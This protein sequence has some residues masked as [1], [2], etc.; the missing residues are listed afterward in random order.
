M[1]RRRTG[2]KEGKQSLLVYGET[3]GISWDLRKRDPEKQQKRL[4][5]RIQVEGKQYENLKEFYEEITHL[6][7][8]AEKEKWERK[9]PLGTRNKERGLSL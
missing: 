4:G 9:G 1:Q 6:L 8:L 7:K 3:R 2:Q 5:G